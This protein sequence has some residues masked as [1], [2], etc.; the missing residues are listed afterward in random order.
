MMQLSMVPLITIPTRDPPDC[1]SCT[2]IDHI[3]S[4]IIGPMPSFVLDSYITDH[5]PIVLL[6]PAI[7]KRSKMQINFRNFSQENIE[8]FLENAPFLIDRF[9]YLEMIQIMTSIL[10]VLFYIQ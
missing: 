5:F 9:L 3:W 6:L 4:N 10:F 8:K 1:S 2:L 7:K